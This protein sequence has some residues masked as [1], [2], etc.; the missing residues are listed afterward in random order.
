MSEEKDIMKLLKLSTSS[1]ICSEYGLDLYEN[2]KNRMD[3][4]GN[5]ISKGKEKKQKISF[6][7]SLSLNNNKLVEIIPVES[8]KKFNILH[9]ED[10]IV[11]YVNENEENYEENIE[12]EE[13]EDDII[14]EKDNG[15][16]GKSCSIF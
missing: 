3:A 4:F 15:K 2:E 16:S 8:Y 7:D 10:G 1:T 6:A 12:E 14:I 11:G 9:I 13:S 5:L